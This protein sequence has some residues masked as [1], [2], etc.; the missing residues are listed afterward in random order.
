MHCNLQLGVQVVKRTIP[1]LHTK[2]GII[3][4]QGPGK[5]QSKGGRTWWPMGAFTYS[6]QSH[7]RSEAATFAH[8]QNEGEPQ[9]AANTLQ[10]EDGTPPM[11]A[12]KFQANIN[13]RVLPLRTG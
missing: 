4:E 7:L 13:L 11:L 10:H 2:L 3:N 8:A 12:F 6:E 1:Y 9:V 5:P